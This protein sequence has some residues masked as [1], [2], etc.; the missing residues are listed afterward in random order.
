[1]VLKL[2][3]ADW[4]PAL[5]DIPG[6]TL[7]DWTSNRMRYSR[8]LQHAHT[9]DISFFSRA[10]DRIER[11]VPEALAQKKTVASRLRRKVA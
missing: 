5:T 11:R 8:G 9:A 3:K 1:V 2:V 10:V 7:V 6:I 4:N